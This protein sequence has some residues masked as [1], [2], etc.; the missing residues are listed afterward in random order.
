M[1]TLHLGEGTPDSLGPTNSGHGA[2]PSF[3]ENKNVPGS[4]RD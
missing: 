4:D 3:A 1:G 2:D